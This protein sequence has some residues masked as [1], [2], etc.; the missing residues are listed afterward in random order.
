M[1]KILEDLIKSV[2]RLEENNKELNK[3][4]EVLEK[5]NKENKIE[6]NTLKIR[7]DI[8]YKG[9]GKTKGDLAKLKIQLVHRNDLQKVLKKG[10]SQRTHAVVEK[11]PGTA[12]YFKRGAGG[13]SKLGARKQYL[14]ETIGHDLIKQPGERNRIMKWINNAEKKKTYP[15]NYT[16]SPAT[17]IGSLKRNDVF[18]KTFKPI[19][20]TREQNSVSWKSSNIYG[21]SKKSHTPSGSQKSVSSKPK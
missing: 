9:W 10:K 5:K 13:R 2:K 7:M 15:Q 17:S 6:M 18:M 11:F 4:Y 14:H 12:P 21:S 1:N 16:K 8:M 20:E 19:R 3:K